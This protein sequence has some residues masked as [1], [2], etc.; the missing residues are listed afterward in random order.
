MA[1]WD[2]EDLKSPENKSDRYKLAFPE[3]YSSAELKEAAK[4]EEQRK[5]DIQKPKEP[6]L[7]E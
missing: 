7:Q 5:N 4:R 2:H 3:H 1:W 6:K